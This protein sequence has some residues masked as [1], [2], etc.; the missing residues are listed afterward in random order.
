MLLISGRNKHNTTT[1]PSLWPP[2]LPPHHHHHP[3]PLHC[4]TGFEQRCTRTCRKTLNS[5][6]HRG[7]TCAGSQ[8]RWRS[9]MNHHANRQ[10]HKQSSS[11][12]RGEVETVDC[13]GK[14]RRRAMTGLRA[15][16]CLIPPTLLVGGEFTFTL[17]FIFLKWNFL[18]TY[19]YVVG[20]Q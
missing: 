19:K 12:A 14:L 15:A 16:L 13:D 7:R 6:M 18:C 3:Q 9:E 20:T 11:A 5:S 4:P 1:S 2:F 8:V 10:S 17:P